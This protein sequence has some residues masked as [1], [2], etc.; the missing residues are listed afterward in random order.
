MKSNG[1]NLVNVLILNTIKR[2]IENIS[3]LYPAYILTV[4]FQRYT[5]K[6]TDI[7]EAS[8]SSI[9]LTPQ[10]ESDAKHEKLLL[11]KGSLVFESDNVEAN[12]KLSYPVF[13][14]NVR[15]HKYPGEWDKWSNSIPYIEI[16]IPKHYCQHGVQDNQCPERAVPPFTNMV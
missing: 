1:Q 12:G 3:P 5:Y 8:A 7:Q 13:E 9:Y 16:S 2:P 6:Y 10:A 11:I 15:R 4:I 14:T